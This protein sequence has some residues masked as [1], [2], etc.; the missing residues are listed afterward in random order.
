[1]NSGANCFL[2]ASSDSAGGSTVIS[3]TGN[4]VTPASTTALELGPTPGPTPVRP[5]HRPTSHGK[6]DSGAPRAGQPFMPDDL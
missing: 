4:P 5:A 2:I 6:R 1:M 3:P